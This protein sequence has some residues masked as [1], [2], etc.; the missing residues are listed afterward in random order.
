MCL[1]DHGLTLNSR[2][3]LFGIIVIISAKII[4][5]AVQ[6]NQMQR[7]CKFLFE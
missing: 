5:A 6:V 3:D 4:W 1:H 7:H 2:S